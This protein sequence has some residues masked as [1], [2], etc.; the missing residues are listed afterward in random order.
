MSF[1]VTFDI[2]D[3]LVINLDTA[4]KIAIDI[5]FEILNEAELLNESVLTGRILSLSSAVA[6]SLTTK[7]RVC[8]CT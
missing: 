1:P 4:R 8:Y 2:K 7:L 5:P 6:E 3:R